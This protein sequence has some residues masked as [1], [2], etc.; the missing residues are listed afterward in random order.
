MKQNPRNNGIT[1]GLNSLNIVMS[2]LHYSVI[3]ENKKITINNK[4]AIL[5]FLCI[6]FTIVCYCLLL[7]AIFFCIIMVLFIILCI[8]NNLVSSVLIL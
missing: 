2:E 8:V 4:I 7:F 3:A 1:I 5:L 6:L